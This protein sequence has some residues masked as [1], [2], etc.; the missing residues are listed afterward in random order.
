MRDVGVR[1]ARQKLLRYR[2][3]EPRGKRWWRWLVLGVAAWAVW[4]LLV[5]DHSVAR[6]LRLESERSRL[7]GELERSKRELGRVEKRVPS[8]TPSPEEAERLLRERHAYARDG[9]WVY[10]IGEDS[11][12][13]STAPAP[14]AKSR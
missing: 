3:P 10:I 8:A 7:S 9:E 14:K 6:L 5:S 4:A 1:I 13:T 2:M 11:T 12:R